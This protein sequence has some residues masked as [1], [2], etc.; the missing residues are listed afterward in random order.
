[1]K[2]IFLLHDAQES[3]WPRKQVIEASGFA[4]EIFDDSRKCLA[5]LA[6]ERPSLLLVDV[7]LKGPNGFEVASEVRRHYTPDELP[8]ILCSWIYRGEMFRKAA[9]EAG[10]QDYL[11]KPLHLR[12]LVDR[13]CEL[14]QQPAPRASPPREL[15]MAQD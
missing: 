5:A 9:F 1:M 3:P 11:L 8:V 7:L 13:V 4:V 12:Q 6:E 14:T 15:E 2:T 10:A